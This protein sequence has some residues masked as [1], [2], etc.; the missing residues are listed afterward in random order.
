M[1]TLANNQPTGEFVIAN[2]TISCNGKSRKNHVGKS[3]L[4]QIRGD[5]IIGATNDAPLVHQ[6]APEVYNIIKRE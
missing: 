4:E 5:P 3:N 6:E 1:N 2:L